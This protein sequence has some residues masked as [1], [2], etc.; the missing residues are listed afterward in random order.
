MEKIIPIKDALLGTLLGRDC[1]YLDA[2]SQD[3]FAN[4]TFKGEI[5]SSLSENPQEGKWV[6][7]TLK[8]S[9]AAAYY[10]CDIDT[11]YN[12]ERCAEENSFS[13]VEKSKW[14][15]RLT[16]Q[17]C[18]KANYRHYRL[19]TYDFVYNIIAKDYEMKLNT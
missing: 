14:L 8:F 16:L 6:P 11:Y 5:N 4:L 7:Y 10:V 12:M 2:F 15:S 3:E 13:I 1:I 9:G 19:F 18:D 17:D